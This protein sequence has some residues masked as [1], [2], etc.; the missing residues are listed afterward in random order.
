MRRQF[1]TCMIA[2][3]IVIA[4]FVTQS[5]TLG[6]ASYVGSLST[7]TSPTGIAGTGY[8][9]TTG[10]T[11]INWSVAELADGTWNYDYNFYV[12]AGNISHFI[13]ERSSGFSLN[14]IFDMRGDFSGITIATFTPPDPSNPSLPGTI[15]GIKFNDVSTTSGGF[16][17]SSTRAPVWG[18]F[19]SKDGTT[20]NTPPTL[21]N[22]AWNA[23]YL[24]P[25]PTDPPSNGS[26]SYKILVPD[27]YTA[28]P[29]ASTIVLACFG[30]LQLLAIR[31]KV[32]K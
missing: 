2:I 32:F 14:D 27:T 12:P 11:Q 5:G 6:L 18:N 4:A 25:T 7:T 1:R 31:R 20:F 21:F 17:F 19:Y 10:P 24:L 8:W 30:T 9:V 3:F 22:T 15:N 13:L 28:V 16:H 26:V 23:G 29:D